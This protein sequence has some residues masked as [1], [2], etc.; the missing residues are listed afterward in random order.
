MQ[1]EIKLD[2]ILQIFENMNTQIACICETWFDSRTG[3]FIAK[4]N[5]AGFD[6]VHAYREGKKRWRNCNY[7]PKFIENKTM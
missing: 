2:N 6:I 4:I 7:L 3:I 1:N 5:E